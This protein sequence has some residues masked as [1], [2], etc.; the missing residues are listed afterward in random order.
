MAVNRL[1]GDVGYETYF[2][3]AKCEVSEWHDGYAPRPSEV[4]LRMEVA[5]ASVPVILELKTPRQAD[6]LIRAIQ[7][8]RATVWPTPGCD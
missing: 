1:P 2:R 6:E 8:M 7:T 5:G 3:V 4:H